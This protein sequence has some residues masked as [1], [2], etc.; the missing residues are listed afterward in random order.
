M[1]PNFIIVQGANPLS[2]LWRAFPELRN[3]FDDGDSEAYYI[4]ARLAN[5]LASH[6]DVHVGH[7]RIILT[8][9]Q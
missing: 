3:E 4:Y 8:S 9:R 7:G 1:E 5:H 6:R 2:Y